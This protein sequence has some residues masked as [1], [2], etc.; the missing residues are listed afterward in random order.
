MKKWML[1]VV[2]VLFLVNGLMMTSCGKTEETSKITGKSAQ[3]GGLKIIVRNAYFDEGMYWEG[4]IVELTLK[5]SREDS[6]HFS[7]WGVE[8]S[9]FYIQDAEGTVYRSPTAYTERK[10]ETD[11]Q[12]APGDFILEPGESRNLIL[13]FF[14]IPKGTTNLELFCKESDGKKRISIPLKIRAEESKLASEQTS[15]E[16]PTA[17]SPSEIVKIFLYAYYDHRSLDHKKASELVSSELSLPGGTLS[18]EELKEQF[19]SEAGGLVEIYNIEITSEIIRGEKADVS[20]IMRWGM[21]GTKKYDEEISF[22][23][24]L[25]KENGEWKITNL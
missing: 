1:I 18:K 5:N 12:K 3:L 22:T 14:D 21:V 16:K 4:I 6:E 19:I 20:V 17:Q 13:G 2:A 8:D 25:V 9:R 10:S 11:Y 23:V 24:D 15:A 7:F